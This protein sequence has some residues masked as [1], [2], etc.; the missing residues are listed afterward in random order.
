MAVTLTVLSV[1]EV[2]AVLAMTYLDLVV[3]MLANCCQT[4]WMFLGW[5]D[6]VMMAGYYQAARIFNDWL[7]VVRLAGCFDI[8]WLAFAEMAGCYQ[9]ARLL[10]DWLPL[11]QQLDF[12]ELAKL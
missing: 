11:F 8:G 1:L 4:E 12:E 2:K 10:L 5:Q 3:V 6:S 9:V 7:A